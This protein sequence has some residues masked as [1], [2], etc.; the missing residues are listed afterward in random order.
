MAMGERRP[1][2]YA[3]RVGAA[4]S[5]HGGG[6]SRAILK[7][8]KGVEYGHSELGILQMTGLFIRGN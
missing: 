7:D 6:L 2:A 4:C 3:A 8:A 5:G 1:G